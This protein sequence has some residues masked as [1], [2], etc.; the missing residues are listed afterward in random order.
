MQV[1]KTNKNP[2]TL[3]QNVLD[4]FSGVEYFEVSTD[5]TRI[6]LLPLQKSRAANVRTCL[7]ELQIG[8]E[9]VKAAMAWARKNP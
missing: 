2:I 9:D 6:I 3:P 7:A 5:G 1:K 4:R 8:E